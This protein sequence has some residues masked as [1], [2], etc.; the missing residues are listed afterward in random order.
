MAARRRKRAR[1]RRGRFSFLY[2]L[3]SLFLILAAIVTGCI[4]FFRANHIVVSGESRYSEEEIIAAT[5]VELG[6]N[7]FQLDK[8][9]MVQQ[10]QTQLPYLDDISITRRL[11]DTLVIT[12]TE[13]QPVAALEYNGEWWLL[14]SS[15]KLLERGDASLA[16]GRAVLLGLTPLSPSVGTRLAVDQEGEEAPKLEALLALLAALDA[17]D[18]TGE[19]TDFIDLTSE[20]E[21]RLGY[22]GTLTVEIPLYSSDFALQA[23]RLQGTLEQLAQQGS[24]ASGTLTLPAEGTRAWLTAQR[25]MPDNLPD[26]S[27]AET[28]AAESGET[29]APESGGTEGAVASPAPSVTPTQPE[30]AQG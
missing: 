8:F 23:R 17:R 1:R 7:L 2:K 16:Q 13:S 20:S 22:G 25:W 15:C 3:L 21:I 28:G 18:M 26:L 10:M 29:A 6:E 4:V 9:R 11:P 12:V 19:I 5:G 27:G 24:T 14:D 30:Q